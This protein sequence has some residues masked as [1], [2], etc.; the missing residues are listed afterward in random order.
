MTFLLVFIVLTIFSILVKLIYFILNRFFFTLVFAVFIGNP[1]IA[2]QETILVGA[3]QTDQYLPLLVHKKIAVVANH[4]SNIGKTH[5][6]D[7]LLSLK[8]KVKRIFSPEHGL[9]GEADAG[10]LIK[11]QVDKKTGLHIISLYGSHKKPSVRDLNGI[12]L[13]IF[14][15]QDVGV[16]F[17]TYIS[18]MHY[19]METCAEQKIPLIILDR[20]NPNGF[21]V[22][23]PT[24]DTVY[25]SFV[26]MHPVPIVHGMTIGEYAQMINGE[27]WLKRGIQCKL[28]V[29]P[30]KNYDHS[31]IYQLPVRPSPNLPNQTAVLLYPSLGF[32]EGTCI[33]IGRGTDYPFQLFGHPSLPNI[34]FSFVPV[35]KVG[36]SKNPPF[37][38]ELCYGYDLREYSI[39]YF[40][41]NPRINL[42][43]LIFAY[44]MFPNK[45]SFFNSYF[46]YLAGS[47]ELKKQ[48]EQGLDAETISK[49]W[50]TGVNEFKKIRRKYLLYKD[51][52]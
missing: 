8:V 34:G 25:H 2:Q 9:R 50:E 14:D 33:S 39:K 48:I 15:M 24:L 35:E 5:L 12:E 16:R 45:E 28:T 52:E 41:D 3:D 42:E 11:N 7:S 49:S 27:H 32:F 51:F 47:P 19:V 1:I 43:W 23:G 30:C 20:P 36:A 31:I 4:S 17:Y 18:T 38:D 26:G 44:K 21:Y 10:E 29:I 46:N 37:K 13:V 40:R 6:V 22:D